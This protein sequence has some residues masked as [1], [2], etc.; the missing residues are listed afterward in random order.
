[1]VSQFT[2]DLAPFLAAGNRDA[3]ES[4]VFLLL[5]DLFYFMAYENACAEDHGLSDNK[6]HGYHHSPP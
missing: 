4:F 3:H 5:N 6:C 1:M 2:V